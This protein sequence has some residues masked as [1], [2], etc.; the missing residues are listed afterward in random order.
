LLFTGIF[1]IS[2][3]FFKDIGINDFKKVVLAEFIQCRGATGPAFTIGDIDDGVGHAV[4]DDLGAVGID[5]VAN[6]IRR[7]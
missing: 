5:K 2:I 1:G 7:L 6:F 3:D 4:P